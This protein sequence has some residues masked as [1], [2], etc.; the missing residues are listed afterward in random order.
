MMLV[1]HYYALFSS[2]LQLTCL[3][4]RLKAWV[5][6]CFKPL[7][8]LCS[9]L[10]MHYVVSTCRDRECKSA[11]DGHKLFLLQHAVVKQYIRFY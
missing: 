8:F 2:N 10:R 1:K 11:G 3:K 5:S 4:L 6:I 9:Y 7:N